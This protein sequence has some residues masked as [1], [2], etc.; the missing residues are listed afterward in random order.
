MYSEAVSYKY[1]IL[2]TN[3]SN[4]DI[5][6]KTHQTMKYLAQTTQAAGL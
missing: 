2:N 4:F 3:Q 5:M 1:I 6:R